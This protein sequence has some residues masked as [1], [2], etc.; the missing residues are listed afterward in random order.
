MILPRELV[1]DWT[2]PQY[3]AGALLRHAVLAVTHE[4]AQVDGQL[5]MVFP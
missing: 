3:D 1:A 4:K 5:E 2:N